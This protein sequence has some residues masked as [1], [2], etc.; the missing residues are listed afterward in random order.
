MRP[1]SRGTI[2]MPRR[3]IRAG[4][5]EAGRISQRSSTVRITVA[6]S[7]VAKRAPRQRRVPPPN[8]IHV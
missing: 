8:G 4:R 2:V 3:S 7:N 1:P 6:I 5:R